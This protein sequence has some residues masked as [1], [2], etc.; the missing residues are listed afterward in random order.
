MDLDC[1]RDA[2]NEDD[3]EVPRLGVGGG[4]KVR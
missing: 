2:R 3:P 4:G 1:L